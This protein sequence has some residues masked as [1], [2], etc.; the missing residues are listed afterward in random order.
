MTSSTSNLQEPIKI[1]ILG[2]ETIHIADELWLNYVADDLIQNVKSDR[3]SDSKFALVTDTNLAADYV[4]AF[5]ESFQR[6]RKAAGT[7]DELLIYTIA[8]GE[9]SKSRDTVGALHDWLATNKCTKDTVI[10]ALGGGVVGDMVGFVAATYMRGVSVVQV[11]TTLLAMVDSS[12][13]GKTAIDIPAGKNLVGAFHQP[14]R[15]YID[16]RFLR[17]LPKREFINGMAEVVKV[18]LARRDAAAVIFSL[19][20]SIDC[21]YL[22]RGRVCSTR[23][24]CRHDQGVPS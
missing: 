15:I 24:Q 14:K 3:N 8:P 13:G 6:A 17:T 2:T 19:T 21:C 11:P 10:I 4:P 7:D 23:R 18:R 12:V 5:Q 9:S 16:L 1:S 22:G 20:Y